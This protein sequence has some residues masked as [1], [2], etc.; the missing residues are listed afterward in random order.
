M[1][2]V[3]RCVAALSLIACL[4]NLPAGNILAT[5]PSD[6]PVHVTLEAEGTFEAGRPATLKLVYRRDESISSFNLVKVT[7]E[8]LGKTVVHSKT[9]WQSDF[10]SS[11][12][13]EELITL[14]IPHGETSGVFIIFYFGKF[15]WPHVK[16]FV[17]TGDT[18][19]I[20]KGDI[21]KDPP[22][23]DDLFGDSALGIKGKPP[24][25]AAESS[26]FFPPPPPPPFVNPDDTNWLIIDSMN[27][28]W[29]GGDR[30][31]TR[32]ADSV[33]LNRSKADKLRDEM[34]EKE[35]TPLDSLDSE[36]YE[37]DGEYFHRLRG[38]YKFR[39]TPGITD[40]KAHHQHRYDSLLAA[41]PDPKLY[42][43][44]FD[45]RDS[46]N[47]RF[48]ESL[49]TKLEPT[50][51]VGLYRAL[52]TRK[53]LNELHKKGIKFKQG[54]ELLRQE[55]EQMER[56]HQEVRRLD[57]LRYEE[58]DS[59][60]RNSESQLDN[61]TQSTIYLEGFEG[62]FPGD[63]TVFDEEPTGGY[64]Y[65]GKVSGIKYTGSSSVW[66]N[67]TGVSPLEGYSNWMDA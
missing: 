45:L 8:P 39:H 12:E 33:R 28:V 22:P 20:H 55:A 16:S 67:G 53:T 18:I 24:R 46:G 38:E 32:P 9:E 37:I 10:S 50:D 3:I 48:A 41:H 35:K 42:D 27:A 49:I 30:P 36:V 19:E 1:K 2:K 64:T 52:V 40:I 51:S 29:I 6:K 47:Y 43:F 15:R 14:T 65:W 58:P 21:T 31:S 44:I 17:S 26:Y 23:F 56:R 5:P 60:Q 54:P 59:I 66:C 13:F 62:F 11:E 25:N 4:V 63:W 57:S 61:E 34:K 7:V